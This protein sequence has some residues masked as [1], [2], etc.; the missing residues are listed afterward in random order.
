LVTLVVTID[1]ALNKYTDY[2]DVSGTFSNAGLS[3]GFYWR[4]I[5]VFA[6][7]PDDPDNRA[8]DILYCYQN[9]YDTADFIPAASVETVEKNITVPI[10]V[11]DT[12]AVSCTLSTSLILATKKD[13]EDHDADPAAHGGLRD[14]IQNNAAAAAAAARAAANA[15]G[16]ADEALEAA[17]A[18]GAKADAAKQAA[19]TATQAAATA[20]ETADKALDAITQLT[21]TIDATPSQSGTLTYTGSAQ[22]PSW[23]SYNPDALTLGGVTSGT[24]A[25]TYTATFTPKEGYM[26][27]DGTDAAR[28]VTW[29][30][31]RAAIS[32][33]P[34]QSGTLTYTGSA[35]SPSWSNYDTTKMTLGGTTNGTNAGTYSATFTP[36]AN[37]QWSDTTTAAKTVTWTIGRA[38]ISATPSQS[39]TLTYTGSAQSPTWSNYDSAKMTVGGTTSSTNAGTYSATFTPTAN[40]QWSDTTTTAKTVTWTIAQAAGSL[41]INKTSLALLTGALTGTITVT[42]TGDGAIT[43]TSS[44]TSVATVSVSGTTVTVT[45]KATGT[46]TIT[47]N[48]AAGTNHT[49]PTS[50]TCSADVKIYNTTLNSNTWALIKSAS[51]SGIGANS[52]SVGATKTITISGTVGN[53]TF[54]S[55]SIDVFI[56]GFNHNSSREGTNRIHFQI[57]KINS[58]DVALIDSGYG[59]NY[60][61]AGY[62]NMNITNTNSGGWS[63][64]RMRTTLLGS[65]YTPTSPL[66]GSLLAALPSDLRA[67]IKSCTKYSDN[68]GGGSDT[69]SYVTSTTDY[70]FLLSEYEYHGARSYANSTEQSYQAQYDY[71]KAG[72]S[73]IKY[74]HSA[75]GS[76]A[77]VWT[78]S[79]YSGNSAGV[80][81]VNTNGNASNHNAYNSYGVAPGF[82]A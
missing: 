2:V 42:R 3:E 68:T 80:C 73:K 18:A 76:T 31:G 51:D 45:G 46:A 69:A 30:I 78:R 75:T 27:N 61:T 47:V 12:T 74:R 26:W 44:D 53:T 71:Y 62:F 82:C 36:T 28:S 39:G 64:S 1:A 77:Y 48:V 24:N 60:T 66:S 55:L 32:T 37:Y 67:V 50:K 40:Y 65:S 14:M 4:E 13:L 8:A 22:S 57:G 10:I 23:N 59:S 9:A 41:T 15:Q 43:A 38:A 21:H 56:L 17:N 5:G 52:W 29:T 72:N 70:L 25:G 63:S 33:T 34:S 7:N 81:I 49:A 6:A 16:T 54:S 35:Q 58:V 79:A 11:G 19:A 20:Q